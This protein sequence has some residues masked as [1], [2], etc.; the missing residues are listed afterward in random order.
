M[1]FQT[2][3][4]RGT[5]QVLGASKLAQSAMMTLK[6]GDTSD[7]ELSNEHP[8]SEQ[9][10]FVVSGSGTATS[11]KPGERARSYKLKTGS[12]IQIGR[13]ERHQ[14]RNSGRKALVTLNFYL[15]PAYTD[16]GEVK[17]RVTKQ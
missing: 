12:L 6:P 8:R 13:G 15:P 2:S 3:A 5:F 7:E 1:H 14:I 11:A 4:K 9:W 17:P 10:M 16:D